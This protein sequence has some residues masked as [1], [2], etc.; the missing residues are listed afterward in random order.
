M[1]EILAAFDDSQDT[2]LAALER[3]TEAD[4][5]ASHAK[6]TVGQRLAFLQF[7]E[8]YHIGQIGLLRRLLGKPGAIR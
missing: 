6:E 7:H 5:A 3:T 8:A 1:E 4:L 2:I